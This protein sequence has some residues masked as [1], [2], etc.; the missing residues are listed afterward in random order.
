MGRV[1]REEVTGEDIAGVV[2][3]WTGIPVVR[4]LEDEAQKLQR[5][6][7]FLHK[8]LVGQDEAVKKVAHAIRRSR[9][10]IGDP[11][12]PIGSFIFLGPTG[13]GKNRAHQSTSLIYVQ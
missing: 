9:V 7:E 8:R 12:K 13:V 3:R 6:E 4:M 2:A 5:M 10:G 11:N 1:L